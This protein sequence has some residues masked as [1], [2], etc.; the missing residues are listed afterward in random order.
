MFRTRAMSWRRLFWGP[1]P[2]SMA[3]G[4]FFDSPG[5]LPGWILT[6]ADAIRA[7]TQSVAKGVPT[8]VYLPKDQWPKEGSGMKGTVC[9]LVPALYGHPDAGTRWGKRCD[10]QLQQGGFV[11]I[12]S[13]P[14]RYMHTTLRAVL[15]MCVDD[16]K[17]AAHKKD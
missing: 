2:A 5:L 9:P 4:T 6:Q 14:G 13:R 1:A 16:I 12:P 3:S 15:S 8:C 10:T 17:L 11:R 7:Y